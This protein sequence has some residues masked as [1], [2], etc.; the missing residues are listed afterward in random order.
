MGEENPRGPPGSPE[1]TE[2][3]GQGEGPS[4]GRAV[5]VGAERQTHPQTRDVPPGCKGKGWGPAVTGRAGGRVRQCVTGVVS[6]GDVNTG[7]C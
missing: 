5:E 7:V 2:L 6:K 1:E 4:W 3:P